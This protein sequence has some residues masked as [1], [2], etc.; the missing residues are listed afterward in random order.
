MTVPGTSAHGVWVRS[1]QT[2]TIDGVKPYKPFPLVASK[3]MN[4][5]LPSWSLF[6]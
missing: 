4:S 2:H 1:L 6:R 3:H 5:A